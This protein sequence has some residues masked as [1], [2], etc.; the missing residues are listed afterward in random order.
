MD[1]DH[2]RLCETEWR[3]GLSYP[4]ERESAKFPE[5]AEIKYVSTLTSDWRT[6]LG[7][8]VLLQFSLNLVSLSCRLCGLRQLN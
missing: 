5:A 6:D 2:D 4:H 3:P 8:K 1:A 7:Y